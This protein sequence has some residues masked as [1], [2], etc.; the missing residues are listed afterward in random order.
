MTVHGLLPERRSTLRDIA[1][2]LLYAPALNALRKCSAVVTLTPR[3]TRRLERLFPI[4]SDKLHTIPNGID[5]DCCERA[6]R[7][8]IRRSPSEQPSVLSVGRAS[9][10]SG[11]ER[12]I[13]AFVGIRQASPNLRF[14]LAGPGTDVLVSRLKPSFPLSVRDGI[15]GT[16]IVTRSALCELYSSHTI[17]ISLGTW[18]GLPTRVLEAM[19]HGCVPLVTESGGMTDVISDGENGFLISD[20]DEV[21][22]AT[23]LRGMV[24]RLDRMDR[25]SAAAIATVRERYH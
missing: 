13:R 14:T 18:E 8:R 22:I 11:T 25:L 19:L 17:F 23:A 1:L 2:G 21:S 24:E 20:E 4:A 3:K 16:G 12:A 15:R 10:D 9:R 5:P 7:T 6:G